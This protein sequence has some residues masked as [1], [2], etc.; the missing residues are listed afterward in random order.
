MRKRRSRSPRGRS[1]SPVVRS[2]DRR[3]RTPRRS[4][5]SRSRSPKRSRSPSGRSRSIGQHRPKG[6]SRSP[7]R[8]GGGRLSPGRSHSPVSKTKRRSTSKSKRRKRSLSPSPR[9]P[10]RRA[11]SRSPRSP[12]EKR[13]KSKQRKQRTAEK[14]TKKKKKSKSH[15]KTKTIDRSRSRSTSRSPRDSK[16][17]SE[18]KRKSDSRSWSRSRSRSIH[19]SDG[20]SGAD[21]P[22]DDLKQALP[23]G[24]TAPA[25]RRKKK[26][27]HKK[28][29]KDQGER[30]VIDLSQDTDPER[31]ISSEALKSDPKQNNKDGEFSF[32]QS[33]RRDNNASEDEK[34]VSRHFFSDGFHW[35]SFMSDFNSRFTRQILQVLGRWSKRASRSLRRATIW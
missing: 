14:R 4:L 12:L 34:P 15:K 3:S 21:L 19:I 23:L 22:K 7:K 32:L 26:T 8:G 18:K 30:V 13:K 25:K 29:T 6:R 24:T 10:K 9:S 33:I 20:D 16:K 35:K 28:V 27:L 11:R 17:L 31:E 5:S 2:P 1:R